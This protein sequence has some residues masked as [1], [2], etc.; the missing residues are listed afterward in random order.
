MLYVVVSRIPLE[1]INTIKSK[2]SWLQTNG[3]DFDNLFVKTIVWLIYPQSQHY[4]QLY[5][6]VVGSN[7]KNI[8]FKTFHMD[9]S[10]ARHIV[11]KVKSLSLQIIC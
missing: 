11:T 5:L 10:L 9:A 3:G 7:N 6:G 1:I 2:S 4:F 8:N